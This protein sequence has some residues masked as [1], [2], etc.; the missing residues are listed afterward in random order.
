MSMA[1]AECNEKMAQP[2]GR[3]IGMIFMPLY[4]WAH[5]GKGVHCVQ[6]WGLHDGAGMRTPFRHP[7]FAHL[8]ER[9]ERVTRTA[10]AKMVS[11]MNTNGVGLL[12]L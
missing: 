3:L 12:Q 11:G 2:S 9:K 7:S 6:R 10:C 5:Q 4:G 1:V 8:V